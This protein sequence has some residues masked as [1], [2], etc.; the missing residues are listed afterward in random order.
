VSVMLFAMRHVL[1]PVMLR[2][3]D[4]RPEKQLNML[5]IKLKSK[6]SKESIKIGSP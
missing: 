5:Q 3:G 1:M 4:E 6:E 2:K